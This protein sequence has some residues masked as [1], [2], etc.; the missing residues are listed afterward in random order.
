MRSDGR[1]AKV[2][3]QE[4]LICSVA[5]AL[6]SGDNPVVACEYLQPAIELADPGF[7]FH[8]QHRGRC[9]FLFSKVGSLTYTIF[10]RFI[11]ILHIPNPSLPL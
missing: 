8:S 1:L 6:D 2:Y 4:R 7:V 10:F 5:R 3:E 9:F 11:R